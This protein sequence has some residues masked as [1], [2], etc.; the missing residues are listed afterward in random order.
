[1][2]TYII[3]PGAAGTAP[4]VT[5]VAGPAP[6]YTTV[7]DHSDTWY[8]VIVTAMTIAVVLGIGWFTTKLIDN[9]NF[10]ACQNDLCKTVVKAG[11]AKD[12]VIIDAA[13]NISVQPKPVTITQPA[14]VIIQTAPPAPVVI[15]PCR[16]GYRLVPGPGIYGVLCA[17]N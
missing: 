13:G 12:G 9:S 14:P 11:L 5:P 6:A 3:T 4:T 16:P 7:R 17:P 1:M 10:G 15:P 2:A 8:Y